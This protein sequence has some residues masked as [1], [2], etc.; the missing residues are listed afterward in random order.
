MPP[1][2]L[3]LAGVEYP[4][5]EAGSFAGEALPQETANERDRMMIQLLDSETRYSGVTFSVHGESS[6]RIV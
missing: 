1:H 3:C 5:V 2:G 6:A 4:D